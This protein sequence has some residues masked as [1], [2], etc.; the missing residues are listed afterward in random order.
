M[1]M[2][3]DRRSGPKSSGENRRLMAGD[4]KD[5]GGATIRPPPGGINAADGTLS[6][7]PAGSVTAIC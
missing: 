5:V 2:R 7:A 6:G 1:T 3:L 4:I